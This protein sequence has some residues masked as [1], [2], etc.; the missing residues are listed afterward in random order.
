MRWLVLALICSCEHLPF[1]T[2]RAGAYAR[3]DE[4]PTRWA[5]DCQFPDSQKWPVRSGFSYWNVLAGHEI[6]RE[7]PDCS[8]TN[9]ITSYLEFVVMAS[10]AQYPYDVP[11]IVGNKV[12][13]PEPT[14]ATT[15]RHMI[16]RSQIIGAVILFYKPWLEETS[17]AIQTSVARHEIGHALGF[18]H[19]GAETCLMHEYV[20][21]EYHRY[22]DKPKSVCR[23]E[24]DIFLALYGGR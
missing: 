9:E 4:L 18:E 5:F 8:K 20:N 12:Q 3:L 10:D 6:F 16:E 24:K 17:L 15:S 1:V 22:N 11:F 13:I 2:D 21:T 7:E 23:E 19:N 14:F